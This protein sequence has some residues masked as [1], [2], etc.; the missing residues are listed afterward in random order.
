MDGISL[1][2]L[3]LNHFI[4]LLLILHT[5][6]V[7]LSHSHRYP[8]AFLLLMGLINGVFVS[9]D[10]FLFYVFWEAML[11]PMF[12]IIGVW[13]GPRRIYAA[14]KFFLYTFLGSVLMLVALLYLYSRAG[15]FSILEMHDTRL[16]LTEQKWL[17]G[18]FL[19][20]FR[21][22]ASHVAGAYLV[23]GRARGGAHRGLRDPGRRAA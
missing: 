21:G 10:A 4:T 15:S 16:G 3:L 23:A 5:R 6:P 18:A 14:L 9:L 20:A 19:L 13:G 22:Q 8:A 2:L 11:I 12:L 17:F 1:P 7:D